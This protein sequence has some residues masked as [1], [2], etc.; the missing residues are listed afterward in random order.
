MCP[1]YCTYCG[2]SWE[3][4]AVEQL[5]LCAMWLC[6]VPASTLTYAYIP[7][8]RWVWLWANIARHVAGS[9]VAVGAVGSVGSVVCVQCLFPVLSSLSLSLSL[10]L[11]FS[12]C[13][14]SLSRP[15]LAVCQRL[16]DWERWTSCVHLASQMQQQYL[17]QSLAN[18]LAWLS[19]RACAGHPVSGD[20]R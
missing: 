16:P 11:Y 10:S 18:D 17:E 13:L 12:L 9:C 8:S 6:R 1:D 3:Y 2:V 19:L 20:V 7:R 15:V 5:E 14:I 4:C